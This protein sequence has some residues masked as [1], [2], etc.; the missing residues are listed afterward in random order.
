M[1]ARESTQAMK[2]NFSFRKKKRYDSNGRENLIWEQWL[3]NA[4]PDC[5]SKIS[6]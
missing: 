4:A 6:G 3:M 5:V 2:S 1:W